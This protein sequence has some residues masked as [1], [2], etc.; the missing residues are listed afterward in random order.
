VGC[1]YPFYYLK[2]DGVYKKKVNGGNENDQWIVNKMPRFDL[3]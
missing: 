2:K 1:S 3:G